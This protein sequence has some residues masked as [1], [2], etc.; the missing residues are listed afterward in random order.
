[1]HKSEP[2]ALR[3]SPR[4]HAASAI[5]LLGLLVLLMGGWQARAESGGTSDA[6]VLS[7]GIG[8]GSRPVVDEVC[9]LSPVRRVTVGDTSALTLTSPDGPA[10]G[11]ADLPD[12][13]GRTAYFRTR[14]NGQGQVVNTPCTDAAVFPYFDF[15]I[16]G[17]EEQIVEVSIRMDGAQ[18]CGGEISLPP[19]DYYVYCPKAWLPTV[20]SHTLRGELDPRNLIEESSENN[21]HATHSFTA[22]AGQEPDI[23]LIAVRAYV[24]TEPDGGG[25][26]IEDPCTWPEVYLYADYRIEGPQSVS[27]TIRILLDGQPF[28]QGTFTDAPG[29][30]TVNCLFPWYVS[31]SLHRLEVVLDPEGLVP[32]I[33]EDNNKATKEFTCGGTIGP[34]LI[35]NSVYFR[36]QPNGE[37]EV[38]ESPCI[39]QTLYPYMD[40]IAIVAGE[41]TFDVALTMDSEVLCTQSVT[42]LAGTGTVSC[43]EPW[44]VTAGG[45]NLYAQVDPLNELPEVDEENNQALMGFESCTPCSPVAVTVNQDPEQVDPAAAQPIRFVVEF[46]EEVTGFSVEDVTLGGTAEGDRTLTV[47]G[48]PKVYLLEISGLTSSGTVTVEIPA[49]VVT[50]MRGCSNMASTSTDN[51][52]TFASGVRLVQSASRRKHGSAGVFDL[53]VPLQGSTGLIEPRTDAPASE[54]QMVLAFNAPPVAVDGSLDCGQEVMVVGGTCHAVTVSDNQ[55]QLLV[56]LSFNRNACVTVS[57][58]GLLGIEGDNDV[59]VVANPGNANR[60]ALVN[61]LDLQAIKNQLNQPLSLNNFLNDINCSGTINILDLQAAKN[62]LNQPAGCP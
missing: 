32:E 24:R 57:L 54:P 51:E 37:G 21:N 46:A 33:S 20:G 43:A 36:D 47:S 11:L 3:R 41:V 50:S 61:I 27:Y 19:G 9:G 15:T 55:L 17:T 42:T 31:G 26:L 45:H 52:V 4:T 18:L 5:G 35:A 28:C 25:E 16:M 12:F 40:Y 29:T 1:M 22:C 44:T 60:A 34:D 8:V 48:G 30:H 59:S 39:G 38:V 58:H 49:N 53:V 13:I 10:Q 14:A 23:D 6:V 62:N 56:G 7:S 2:K